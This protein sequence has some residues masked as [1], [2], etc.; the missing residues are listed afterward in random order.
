MPIMN[1]ITFGALLFLCASSFTLVFGLMRVVNE[2]RYAV[3]TGY[4]GFI[5]PAGHENWILASWEEL[6]PW[7]S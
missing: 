5:Y 6:W 1:G 4:V 2:L 3:S 7:L